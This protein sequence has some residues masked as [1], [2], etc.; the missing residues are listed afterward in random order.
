[1]PKLK[2]HKGAQKRFKVNGAGKLM[3]PKGP[4]SHFRRRRS[5]RVKQQL[6]KMLLADKTVA[7]RLLKK[8]I[9]YGT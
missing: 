6:D 4:K 9:P 5:Q 1:M 2:T 7:K 3:Q 8:V